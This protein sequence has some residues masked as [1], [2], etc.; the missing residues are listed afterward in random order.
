[1]ILRDPPDD[2]SYSTYENVITTMKIETSS[3]STSIHNPFEIN[4]KTVIST[5]SDSCT[6]GVSDY[7]IIF[8]IDS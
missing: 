7:D 4:F 5:D 6:G 1:M 3:T 8:V 2:L